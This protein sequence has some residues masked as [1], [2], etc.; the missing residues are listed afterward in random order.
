[1][2]RI[3][4]K[5][6][7][8]LDFS[9]HSLGGGLAE[10]ASIATGKRAKTFN[11]AGVNPLTISSIIFDEIMETGV[12]PEVYN[13][14]NLVD[15]FYV[16]GEVLSTFQDSLFFVP[17]AGGRRIPL[18]PGSA[19]NFFSQHGSGNVCNSLATPCNY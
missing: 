15:A 7:V 19:D 11:A 17:S 14:D 13:S 3:A 9:G 1:M 4:D 5:L 16:K 8:K 18:E 6:K 10:T 12:A 2:A